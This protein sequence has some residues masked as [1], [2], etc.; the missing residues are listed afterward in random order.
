[1]HLQA[2][3]LK[4]V[5]FCGVNLEVEFSKRTHIAGPNA[6][7]KSTIANAISYIFTNRNVAGQTEGSGFDIKD[8]IN[9][10]NN[11]L[12]HVCTLEFEK[13]D[14]SLLTLEKQVI[15]VYERKKASET[16]TIKGT[17]TKYFIDGDPKS[18]SD[19]DDY[20]KAIIP[21]S[22][23]RILMDPMAFPALHWEKQR[24]ILE[25][26]A[27]KITN[28]KVLDAMEADGKDTTALKELFAS[29]KSTKDRLDRVDLEIKT[30][31]EEKAKIRPAI[32]ENVSFINS[33]GVINETAANK[34]I[35]RLNGEISKIDEA[36]TNKQNAINLVSETTRKKNKQLNDLKQTADDIERVHKIAFNKDKSEFDTS[37][38]NIDNKIVSLVSQKQSKTQLLETLNK[39]NAEYLNT[40]NDLKTQWGVEEAK[41]FPEFDK[42][43][44]LCSECGKKH[45]PD[46][47]HETEELLK[48]NFLNKKKKTLEDLKAKFEKLKVDK[49]ANDDLITTVTT[50]IT[51]LETQLKAVEKEK[52]DLKVKIDAKEEVVS[53]E[54][55]LKA[56]VDHIA[57]LESIK[58]LEAELSKPK[59]QDE[60]SQN[61]LV[62]KTNRDEFTRLIDAQKEIL[63]NAKSI[64]NRTDRNTELAE[65]EKNLAQIIA[66]FE[67]EKILIKD[68]I[69][70]R[71]NLV[72]GSV[73]T[74]FEYVNFK[75]FS[76]NI[77]TQE[78]VEYCEIW[79]DGKPYTALNT[80]NK[81]NAG[82]D[83]INTLSKHYG[84]Y[85]PIVV[86]NAESV[87]NFIPVES[88][89]I[90]LSVVAGPDGGNY[91]VT[92]L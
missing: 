86:D 53:V 22:L 7:R 90:T 71:M 12:P 49:K 8:T 75:M 74:H 26:M 29:G 38:S 62:L 11:R 54:D 39:N 9:T 40:A 17:T 19:Y 78:D 28:E 87:N 36:L 65:K 21:E 32:E 44:F 56:D 60:D 48:T 46:K 25:Q 4:L 82:L 63:N 55:R 2:T 5:N 84:V 24:A 92:Q 18:K 45:D 43:N 3:K 88:Q 35:T 58:A 76:T 37:I 80:A 89:L 42:E 73:R 81:V 79:K 10:D 23:L 14:G 50:A 68:F 15:Q 6:S 85:L 67:K 52:A 77:T 30:N 70:F 61:N 66:N 47:I 83:V 16:E 27:G 31:K 69:L 59:D 41:D 72:E 51:D 91:T 64:K 57:T 13:K 34:E 33:L 1:M 20:L